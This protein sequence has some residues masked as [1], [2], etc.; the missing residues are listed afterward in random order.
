MAVHDP[1]SPEACLALDPTC[2]YLDFHERLTLLS[3]PASNHGHPHAD[4]THLLAGYD[5]GYY[6]YLSAQVFAA[7]IFEEFADRPRNHET[8]ER[9]RSRI[10]ERGASMDEMQNLRDF[11]GREPDSR[12]LFRA[13]QGETPAK[14]SEIKG[15]EE[16]QLLSS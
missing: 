12:A 16:P 1:Q 15:K 7:D 9:Y 8:W 4:F 2:L 5:A 3:H 6:S 10:L 11:L 13:P 14:P